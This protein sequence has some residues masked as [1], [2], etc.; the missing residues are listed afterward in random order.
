MLHAKLAAPLWLPAAS[1]AFTEKVW[2]PWLRREY[3]CGF[4]Q[5]LNPLASSWQ[6]KLTPASLSVNLKVALVCFVEFAGVDVIVGVGGVV[7]STLQV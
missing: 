3:P 5:A 1:C 7:V 2:L 4:E 6:R